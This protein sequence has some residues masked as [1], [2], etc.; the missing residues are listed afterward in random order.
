[1]PDTHPAFRAVYT[2]ILTSSI[3]GAVGDLI[4]ALTGDE[5]VVGSILGKIVNGDD[6][7]NAIGGIINSAIKGDT[8]VIGNIVND[9]F[10]AFS[11][12]GSD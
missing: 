2:N 7:S 1:M 12:K 8:S 10:K 11:L 6:L 9:F 5:N 4:S 3:N